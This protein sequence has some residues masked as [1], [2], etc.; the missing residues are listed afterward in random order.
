MKR[1][2]RFSLVAVFCPFLLLGF[3]FLSCKSKPAPPIT[4]AAGPV[5][6][7][8]LVFNGIEAEGPLNLNLSFKLETNNPDPS[9]RQVKIESWRV[10]IEGQNVSFAFNLDYPQD[11]IFPANSST[12]LRLSMDVAALAE[13]GFAP[14][15]D[16]SLSLITELLFQPGSAAAVK[17]EVS[18][19]A[20]FPGVQAPV[21]SISSIAILKAELVNT[22][23]RVGLLIDNPNPFE[24]ELSAFS[25]QLYGNGMFWAEGQE[26][27]LIRIPGKSSV[28]GYIFMMMNFIDMDRNLLNQI[29]NLVSVNYRFAGET[30][31]STGVG[32]LPVFGT[33]FNLSG[34]SIVLEN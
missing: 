22:R 10:N 5:P 7:A 16:Y 11:G 27:N 15:D 12:P 6:S 2:T 25:Y 4:E 33:S 31:V 30:Q 17:F 20:E 8:S 3:L 28:A 34:S 24:V 1:F 14:K 29:I 13:K 21:F 32:Y 19:L 18:G 9:V 23:F 26:K